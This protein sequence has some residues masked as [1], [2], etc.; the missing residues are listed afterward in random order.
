MSAFG[1][2]RTSKAIHFLEKGR[3]RFVAGV[4]LR[5]VV[6]QLALRVGHNSYCYFL[7]SKVLTR[8]GR[9]SV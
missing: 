5:S 4:T 2:K 8:K 3:N 1:T 7:F 6:P 9:R